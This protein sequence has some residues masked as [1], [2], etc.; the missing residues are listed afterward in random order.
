[1]RMRKRS[2]NR[3]RLCITQ[4]CLVVALVLPSSAAVSATLDEAQVKAAFIYNFAKYIE[5]P[6]DAFVSPEQPLSVCSIGHDAVDQALAGIGGKVVR[7]RV[8]EVRHGVP[9]EALHA[10]HI[11]FIAQSEARRAAQLLSD[12]VG[13]TLTVSD[14]DDFIDIGGGIGLVRADDRIQFEVNSSA[15]ARANLKASSQLLKLARNVGGMRGGK[16]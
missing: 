14:I 10:C 8:L 13:S 6:A 11:V 15:L 7:G 3:F 1:M 9:A 4:I 2:T 12:M 16:N 5:W